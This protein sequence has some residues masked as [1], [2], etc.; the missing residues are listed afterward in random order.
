[1]HIECGK[2]LIPRDMIRIRVSI[3]EFIGLIVL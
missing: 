2:E 1:M 3:E